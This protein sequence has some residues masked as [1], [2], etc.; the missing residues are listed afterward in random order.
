MKD[1]KLALYTLPFLFVGLVVPV[2]GVFAAKH[3]AEAECA[4]KGGK[5]ERIDSC[6]LP[7][8]GP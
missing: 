1:W 4:G 6:A 5:L 3:K 8:K 2:Y 7:K